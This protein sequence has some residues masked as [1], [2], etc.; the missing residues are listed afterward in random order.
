MGL[1][2]STT[3]LINLYLASLPFFFA[4]VVVFGGVRLAHAQDAFSREADIDAWR[5]AQFEAEDPLSQNPP[6]GEISASN[7]RS[8]QLEAESAG[9]PGSLASKLSFE[10]T[11]AVASPFDPAHCFSADC[12]SSEEYLTPLTSQ[13][14]NIPLFI[15]ASHRWT[16]RRREL[17]LQVGVRVPLAIFWQKNSSQGALLSSFSLPE[18]SH[19]FQ[20]DRTSQSLDLGNPIPTA[21]EPMG[22]LASRTGVL[23]SQ[24]NGNAP[25]LESAEEGSCRLRSLLHELL[26]RA[27]VSS[28]LVVASTAISKA[29]HRARLSGLAPELRLRGVHGLDRTRSLEQNGGYYGDSVQRDGYDALV[30]ARLTFRLG[31]LLFARQEPTM[32]RLKLQVLNERKKLHLQVVQA[33][34]R[35]AEANG[36]LTLESQGVLQLHPDEV[37]AAR[38]SRLQWEL[39]L[40]VLSGG[41]FTLQRQKFDELLQEPGVGRASC[42]SQGR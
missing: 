41:W 3:A 33:L 35:W 36:K 29:V 19:S 4:G 38:V 2:V 10:N 16:L 17:L 31:R 5:D 30:E 23:A 28:G 15:N 40:D 42:P 22:P 32:Q 13:V 25:V 6:V 18:M 11:Q 8:H 21:V 7:Y 37:Y 39:E 24:A 26:S 1:M 34:T 27:E 14:P 20:K 12:G 9:R